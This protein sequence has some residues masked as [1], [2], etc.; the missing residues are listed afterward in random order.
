MRYAQ[1]RSLLSVLTKDRGL[2]VA[3]V[4]YDLPCS[5]SPA[6]FLGR[7]HRKDQLK[8]SGRGEEGLLISTSL[9]ASKI[10]CLED[11]IRTRQALYGMPSGPGLESLE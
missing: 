3:G 9:E 4:K 5:V 2:V 11:L 10:I 6:G 1:Q 8:S 7:Q